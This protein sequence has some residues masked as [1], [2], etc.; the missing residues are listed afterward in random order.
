MCLCQEEE[1]MQAAATEEEIPSKGE[2]QEINLPEIL[3][4][5]AMAKMDQPQ[6]PTSA[7]K[8][9]AFEARGLAL[10]PA[11]AAAPA[12]PARKWLSFS[13]PKSG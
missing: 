10:P 2:A 3:L 4:P 6:S 11:A 7:Y 8:P 5:R 1:P 13:K 12:K 9:G